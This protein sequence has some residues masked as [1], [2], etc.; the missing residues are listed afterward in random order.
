[1][2]TVIIQLELLL[3]NLLMLEPGLEVGRDGI[4]VPFEMA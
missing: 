2:M 4:P 1:M 3:P